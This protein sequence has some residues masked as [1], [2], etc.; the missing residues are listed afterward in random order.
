MAKRSKKSMAKNIKKH[1]SRSGFTLN[2]EKI[3]EQNA[4]AID[5][6][7]NVMIMLTD[8]LAGQEDVFAEMIDILSV[9][10]EN[11]KDRQKQAELIAKKSAA[12]IVKIE[13]QIEK[14]KDP[15]K[16][17]KLQDAANVLKTQGISA[18][19]IARPQR[20]PSTFSEMLQNAIFGVTPD[21]KQQAGGFLPALG[22][23]AKE[24][25]MLTKLM[26]GIAP[27]QKTGAE[28][29]E[30]LLQQGRKRMAGQERIE[31]V[32][33]SVIE[34]IITKS[35]SK[36]K[37]ES[38]E[39]ETEKG[40]KKKT[41]VATATSKETLNFYDNVMEGLN[42]VVMNQSETNKLLSA[43]TPADDTPA[44][45]ASPAN[46]E[47]VP[48][49]PAT[50]ADDLISGYGDRVLTTPAGSYALNNA[51]DVIAGTNLFPKGSVRM[52]TMLASGSSS[53]TQLLSASTRTNADDIA[54]IASATPPTIVM[55]IGG[56]GGGGGGTVINNVDNSSVSS[57]GGGGGTASVVYI[58]DVHNSH[59]RFQDKRLTSLFA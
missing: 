35:E 30:G 17:K 44:P 37:K 43:L 1:F 24:K 49:I 26:F 58:R 28:G 39:G 2:P 55:P 23:V 8:I 15:E 56:G 36:K 9:I 20:L 6:I 51:D 50:P 3:A 18:Y 33:S 5:Q 14:E 4:R 22:Q 40:K 31:E 57:G 53:S 38:V 42:L 27:K 21:R 48:D 13:K 12:A 19:S 10:P 45:S 54:N 52:G 16:K 59:I 46:A 34:K 7:G 41:V 32:S 11:S 25:M 29:F 47:S